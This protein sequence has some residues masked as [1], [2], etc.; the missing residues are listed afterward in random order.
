MDEIEITIQEQFWLEQHGGRGTKDVHLGI[1][2]KKF[3]LMYN[4]DSQFKTERV[5]VGT[6]LPHWTPDKRK[7]PICR[8]HQNNPLECASYY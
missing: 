5:P 6:A 7:H 1:D 4:P 2:G 8:Q 3:V